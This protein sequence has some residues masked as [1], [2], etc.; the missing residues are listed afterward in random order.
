M[1][2]ITSYKVKINGYNCIFEDTLKI[3][4]REAVRR[5]YIRPMPRLHCDSIWAWSVH[6]FCCYTCL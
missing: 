2:V 6:T 1:Q 5:K 4:R 3:Y